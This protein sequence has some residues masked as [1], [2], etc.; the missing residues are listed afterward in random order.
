[1]FESSVPNIP[2]KHSKHCRYRLVCPVVNFRTSGVS[3]SKHLVIKKEK[4]KDQLVA[5]QV[6]T[7]RCV[8]LHWSTSLLKDVKERDPFLDIN[9]MLVSVT[10]PLSGSIM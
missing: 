4:K 6:G 1:M 5:E 7:V 3:W 10:L 9:S 8:L 2:T